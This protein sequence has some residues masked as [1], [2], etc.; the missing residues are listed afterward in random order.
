MLEFFY[1]HRPDVGS[2]PP[3]SPS[4]LTKKER[5]MTINTK[6]NP[7]RARRT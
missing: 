1:A 2:F 5:T 4:S 3:F 7:C 6:S